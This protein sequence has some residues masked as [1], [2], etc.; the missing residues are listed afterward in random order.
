V[1][2]ASG[3]AQARLLLS[4]CPLVPPHPVHALRGAEE[5]AGDFAGGSLTSPRDSG[6]TASS[7]TGA[8]AVGVAGTL[9]AGE[10]TSLGGGT[11]T[12]ASSVGGDDA[13]SSVGGETES[14]AT[15]AGSDHGPG[16]RGGLRLPL[17]AAPGGGLFRTSSA[18]GVAALSEA[19]TSGLG[20][21][22]SPAAVASGAGSAVSPNLRSRSG[23]AVGFGGEPPGTPGARGGP[24]SPARAGNGGGGAAPTLKRAATM[25]KAATRLRTS[26]TSGAGAVA[27]GVGSSGGA[28]G[29]VGG[30]SGGGGGSALVL[31]P[32]PATA[33]SGSG[34]AV[35]S[36]GAGWEA[37]GAGGGVSTA[38][39]TA[40][41]DHIPY[42]N[43]K[44]TRWV[45]IIEEGVGGVG[46]GLRA[47]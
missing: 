38:S 11:G 46:R 28:G 39:V 2:T 8:G 31:P 40:G 15:A 9:E 36:L 3:G 17:R 1:F 27:T 47:R 14:V 43:S 20:R 37:G 30:S 12:G 32:M 33:R 42:R 13:H 18:R 10:A 16:A 19:V 22:I 26:I 24:G 21:A 35:S 34:G 41:G 4:K 25:V 7:G 5:G 45:P 44:L 23:S 29:G 6:T